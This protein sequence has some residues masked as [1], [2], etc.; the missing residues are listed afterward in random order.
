MIRSLAKLWNVNP[1]FDPQNVM[2]FGIAASQRLGNTPGEIRAAMRR[3]QNAMAEVPG[4]QAVSLSVGST[5]MAG[6]S[7]F[8]LWLDS[9]PMPSSQ[10]EMKVSLLYSVQP[11]YLEVMKIP[12]ERGRFLA[13]SDTEKTAPVIVIDEEFAKRYFGNSDPIGRHVNLDVVNVTAEVVG[14]VGHVKQW[15]MDEDSSN[16]IQ[17]QSYFSMAQIP[18]AFMLMLAHGVQAIVRVNPNMLANASPISQA[19]GT[20]NSQMVVYGTK[21]MTEIVADSLAQKRF[22]MMLLGTFAALATVLSSV[23]IYGVISY[24]A[25]QRTHEI[26]IRM[27]MGAE[28]RDVLRMMLG[29]AGKMALIGVGIGLMA[30]FGLMRLMSSMLFGVSTHDPQTFLGVAVLLTLVALAACLVPARRATRVDP[31]VALRYE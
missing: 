8:P 3:L 16:S 7:E 18:D 23:G 6:D 24:I 14:V 2:T 21:T 30:S 4:V 20:V 12:L 11:D 22:A 13:E 9:E 26:G 25:G 19:V 28:R 27:A 15:G 1:G 29:Q 5:P 31:M 17:A 10:S